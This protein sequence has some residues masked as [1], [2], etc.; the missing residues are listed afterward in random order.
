[1]VDIQLT[2]T[3]HSKVLQI[4]LSGKNKGKNPVLNGQCYRCGEKH[5]ALTCRFKEVQCLKCGKRGHLAKTC[6]ST[7]AGKTNK[8]YN[9]QPWK[10]KEEKKEQPIHLKMFTLRPCTPLSLKRNRGLMKSP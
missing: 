1:M 9:K 5:E 8:G 10:K 4:N 2:E 3:T 7:T 6:R